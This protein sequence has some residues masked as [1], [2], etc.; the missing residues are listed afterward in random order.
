MV[1]RLNAP[2]GSG[3]DGDFR[4][5]PLGVR[6]VGQVGA[7]GEGLLIKDTRKDGTWVARP[8]WVRRQGINSFAGQPLAFRGEVLGV[9]GIF[10]RVA[11]DEE[12]FDWL[13]T[14]GNHAAVSIT[15]ARAF[16]EITEL[17]VRLEEERDYLR[18]EVAESKHVGE[19]I[20]ESPALKA[21]LQ[22]MSLVAATDSNVLILGESG[23]GKELVARAI[24]DQ[25][26]RRDGPLVRVNCASIPKDLFESEF[27]GHVRGSF[28]GAH[29]DR[30][31]RFELAD[32]GTLLL[33][34]V[35]EIPMELQ[36]KL[37]RVPQ[38]G[39]FERVG[40]EK[41]RGVSVRV[42]A[43]TNRN[44]EQEVAAGRFRRDLYYRL[45]FRSCRRPS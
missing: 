28:T 4:R 38:E 18:E 17:R 40:D 25:S 35:G 12:S 45:M 7:S 42:V 22:K 10:S 32:G 3:L 29:R 21:V 13:R 16:Q 30:T 5:I 8:E 36:G 19:I 11:L 26:A 44:L 41:T 2:Y 15:N 43:A 24:H 9:L 33:D 27:F 1:G 37:L 23:T 31:G 14:F 34:E 39:Q 20:G 6:K